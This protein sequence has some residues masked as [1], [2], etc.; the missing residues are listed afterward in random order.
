MCKRLS[1]LLSFLLLILPGICP[2]ATGRSLEEEAATLPEVVVTATRSTQQAEKVPAH[3]TVISEAE[4]QNS[5]AKT[6][7]D[8]LRA[9]QGIV[10]RNLLGNGKNALV[11][12]RGFGETGAYNTLVLV[13]GRRVNGIDLSGVDWT[14][15]PVDQVRRIEIVHGTGSVLYGDNAVG[16]VIHIITR[17]PR[18]TFTANGGI[19]LGSY[20]RHRLEASVG[21]GRDRIAA[22]LFASR[23]QTD[24]YR[25]NNDYDSKDAGGKFVFDATESLAF[26]LNAAYHEDAY[27]LPG[28]L[29]QAQLDADRK[30]SANPYDEGESKDTYL[31]GG[32]DLAVGSQGNLVADLFYRYR[33]SDAVF[34]D[35]TSPMATD[36]TSTTWGITP[37]YIWDGSLS[38]HGNTLIVGIDYYAAEQ[39]TDSFGGWLIP[40]GTKSAVANISRDSVGVYISNEFSILENLIL[41]VGARHEKVSYD[42]RQEDLT[43]FL[44]P[45]DDDVDDSE[46][47]YN[48]GLTYRYAGGS[49]VFVRINRSF[50]FPLTDE[51]V[52]TDWGTFTI[53]ANTD[54]KPQT[55]RHYETG[56]KH[57]ITPGIFANL[58][59]FRAEINNELFYNPSTFG[60]ENHPETLHQGVEIG[61][62]AALTDKIN[63]FASYT[64][65]NAT[66]EKAPYR[67]N[68]V[69]AVPNH[70]AGLGF[71]ISDLA[72][73]GLDF[74]ANYHY[75]G[76]SYA[77]SDQANHFE[78]LKAYYTID[79]RL[80]YQWKKLKAFVGV[81]NITD[82]KY[83]EYA[84][85]DT[86]LTQRNFYPAPD[87]NWVAGFQ[88]IY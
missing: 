77:I 24:G 13:D 66:F 59:L 21:G 40:M 64:Y 53:K 17:I 31:K 82:Q 18:E 39:D 51:I 85:M 65:E 2:A 54:L 32:L 58:T 8:L 57:Y 33:S 42:L 49:S 23:D 37:R 20:G 1:V 61:G 41:S 67:D 6:I 27:G 86:F 16:G 80:S 26:N 69:P 12:L 4:I 76:A 7:P 5:N 44:G 70:K 78:K 68:D 43:G 30:S 28:P 63:V 60:N 29:T 3:V 34:P 22:S 19:T 10:V 50:R 11:D 84:V 83:S 45:L 81:N 48:A 47:A 36:S 62:K 87:R 79:T 46:N 15:I 9:Q 73:P 52:Y 25:V 72:T 14:Q 56:I 74:L 88:Y 55:G 35:A 38:G 75:T 71:Q